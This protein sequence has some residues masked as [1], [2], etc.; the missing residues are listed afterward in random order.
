[1]TKISLLGRLPVSGLVCKEL[2]GSHTNLTSKKLNKVKNELF[3]NTS[4]KQSHG[5]TTS[6][7][8]VETDRLEKEHHHSLQE[9]PTGR[10]LH[11]T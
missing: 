1:M 8:I 6:P 4:E 2:G 7:K 5:E 3:L 11:R 10:K 9:K